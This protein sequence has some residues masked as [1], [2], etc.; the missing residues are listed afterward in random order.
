[1][2]MFDAGRN[3]SVVSLSD[4]S[5]WGFGQNVDGQLGFE[6][7]V[8][9]FQPEEIVRF[10][11]VP[12]AQIACGSRQTSLLTRTGAMHVFGWVL[13]EGRG[14]PEFKHVL[15]LK[16]S[17]KFNMTLGERSISSLHSGSTHTLL[18][19]DDG[20]VRVVGENI[21]NIL[22]RFDE[23]AF[24]PQLVTYESNEPLIIAKPCCR[25]PQSDVRS[26]GNH[27]MKLLRDE[28]D[29]NVVLKSLGGEAYNLHR[30]VLAVRC[31]KLLENVGIP[32]SSRACAQLFEYIY[33]QR[34]SSLTELSA[35][36][37]VQ[38]IQTAQECSPYLGLLAY[39]AEVTF[40][41]LIS[42]D[43]EENLVVA[44]STEVMESILGE[45]AISCLSDHLRTNNLSDADLL[46]VP[47]HVLSKVAI[48]SHSTTKKRPVVTTREEKPL[49]DCFLSVLE[50]GEY[51]DFE[52]RF[53]DPE[54][55]PLKVHGALISRMAFFEALLRRSQTRTFVSQTPRSSMMALLKYIYGGSMSFTPWE[56]LYLMSPENG[57][58]FY[59]AGVA[60]SNA[61]VDMLNARLQASLAEMPIEDSVTALLQ[62]RSLG[63]SEAETVL[64]DLLADNFHD[65]ENLL[66]QLKE[67][68][69]LIIQ[70]QVI[71]SLLSK[72][73]ELQGED[74][75]FVDK[76]ASMNGLINE[77]F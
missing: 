63:I 11:N 41:Q 66:D 49:E 30:V 50:S 42:A 34:C 22:V 35:L 12:L 31:P 37:L 3:H 32:L 17:D 72:I 76:N 52:I 58:S 59:F 74:G 9:R 46:R 14:R 15:P 77:E 26:L 24:P 18:C 51:G 6:E 61:E 75:S 73:E 67:Q 1:M 40:V 33:S 36:E 27:L 62:A 2:K 53:P 54:S 47:A 19:L 45:W 71:Y 7:R 44:E 20:S 28:L 13:V 69:L 5:L 43:K 29:A 57:V 23:R 38:L 55:K 70:K 21:E 39:K 10:R 64:V 25:D 48:A 56:A 16:Y 65:I 4:D 8:D 60:E 68:D